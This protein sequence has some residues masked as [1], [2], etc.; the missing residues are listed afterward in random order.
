MMHFLPHNIYSAANI[1]Y[2]QTSIENMSAI[3]LKCE[4]KLPNN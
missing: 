1:F 4:N 3:C 2:F